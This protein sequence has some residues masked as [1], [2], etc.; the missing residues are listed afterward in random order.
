LNRVFGFFIGISLVYFGVFMN[1]KLNK[2]ETRTWF[3]TLVPLMIYNFLNML[4]HASAGVTILFLEPSNQRSLYFNQV[5]INLIE[6]CFI[7]NL[8]KNLDSGDFT[9]LQIFWWRYI[10]VVFNVLFASGMIVYESMNNLKD[11]PPDYIQEPTTP[12]PSYTEAIN[13]KGLNQV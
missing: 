6:V 2:E 5:F 3:T 12:P 10:I 9:G 8:G 13:E 1:E 4:T 11:A 7:W